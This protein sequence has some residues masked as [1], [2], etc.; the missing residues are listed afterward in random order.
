M[1]I[2]SSAQGVWAPFERVGEIVATLGRRFPPHS[3][4]AE[5]VLTYMVE[6][7]ASYELPPG[8]PTALEPGAVGLLVSSAK[9]VHTL[10]PSRG[11]TIRWFSL[12][13]DLPAGAAVPTRAQFDRPA[14]SAPQADG[15]VTRRLV[16]P[17]ASVTSAMGLE[18]EE[19]GFV[20]AGTSFRRIGHERRG[21][22][23]ALSGRGDV[24]GQAIEIGEAALVENVS[25]IALRGSTGFRSLVATVPKPT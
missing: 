12:V 7:L 21:V 6:G 24:D 17:A 18:V 11:T 14:T 8:P 13:A 3:H 1:V 10:K 15:S 9:V 2:P 19:V 16:G 4:E 20:T 25:G 5:E 22:V 23:Y